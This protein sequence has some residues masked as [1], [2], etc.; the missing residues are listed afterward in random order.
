MNIESITLQKA[1]M[2]Y[3]KNNKLDSLKKNLQWD[4]NIIKEFIYALI[5]ITQTM[6]YQLFNINFVISYLFLLIMMVVMDIVVVVVS[7]SVT[8]FP[9]VG[10]V[11]FNTP[12]NKEAVQH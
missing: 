11:V 6:N 10:G 7:I 12:K 4:I 3:L 5:F 8:V 1:S 2:G 9:T